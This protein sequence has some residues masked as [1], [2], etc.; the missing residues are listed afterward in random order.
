MINHLWQTTI[1]VACAALL[2]IA[3]RNNRASV[4]HWLWFSAS[5]KFL[6]PFALLTGLGSQIEPAAAP[7]APTVIAAAQQVA[8]PFS[9]STYSAPVPQ[10]FDWTPWLL[11]AWALGSLIVL[12]L[13][14]RAWLRVRAIAASSRRVDM[15]IP[16]EVRSAPGLLEPGVAGLFRPVLLLPEGIETHLTPQQLETV[17]NHELCHIRRRDNLLAAIH[18][19]VEG[20]FWF[21]PLVWWIGK[22]LVDERER[23]CDESVVEQGGDPRDYA[24]AIILVCR[25]YVESPLACVSGV[26]GAD[27][28]KRI[29]LIM[30]G[31]SLLHLDW[32]KKFLLA[33]AALIAAFVPFLAG[34]ARAQSDSKA[35]EVASIRLQGGDPGTIAVSEVSK[36]RFA[37][38]ENTFRLMVFAFK[39]PGCRM[40]VLTGEACPLISGEPSWMR[41]E[42]YTIQAT[43]PPGTRDYNMSDY[44]EGRADDLYAMVRKLFESRFN[45]KYHLESRDVSVYR[46]TVTRGGAKLPSSQSKMVTMPDGTTARERFFGFRPAPATGGDIILRSR[47]FSLKDMASVL[48]DM[49]NR[50]VFDRTGIPGEFDFDMPF[51]PDPDN[52]GPGIEL[53]GPGLF[54]AFQEQLGLRLESAKEKMDVIVIDSIDRPSQN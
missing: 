24:D 43:T 29:E 30:T 20:I 21:H 48:S 40:S 26:T 39:L 44:I 47:G 51:P 16:V 28:T 14:A 2:S 22:R 31:R 54:T 52:H 10:P 35:F 18:M 3:L 9:E 6:I 11:A 7:V 38:T 42:R 1:F 12:F 5:A 23:A 33:A 27:L 17:L 41:Q 19:V 34:I 49:L 13:R 15:G 45:L 8:M 4:R 53:R 32:G 37:V 50:P 46:I 36:G 25:R